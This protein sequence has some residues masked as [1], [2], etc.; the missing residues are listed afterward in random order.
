MFDENFPHPGSSYSR[1]LLD[2][3]SDLR[4]YEYDLRV[5]VW[6]ADL[7]AIFRSYN[8]LRISNQRHQLVSCDDI[9]KDPYADDLSV[10]CGWGTD[11]GVDFQ[12]NIGVVSCRSK[13]SQYFHPKK[14]PNGQIQVIRREY[15]GNCPEQGKFYYICR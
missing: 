4:D 1:R 6:N 12:G 13:F 3:I 5:G 10:L 9:D 2:Q 8:P 7:P 14:D 11:L 15:V